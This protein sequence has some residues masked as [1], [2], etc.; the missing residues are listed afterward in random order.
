MFWEPLGATAKMSVCVH[1][2]APMNRADAY[3]EK[4]VPYTLSWRIF[5]IKSR[6]RNPLD[7]RMRM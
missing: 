2:D 6:G 3:D 5:P 4:T 1:S 7:K